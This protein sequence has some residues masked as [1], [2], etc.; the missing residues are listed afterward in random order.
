MSTGNMGNLPIIIIP[1]VCREKGSPFGDPDVCHVYG[2]AYASLSMA[3]YDFVSFVW[4]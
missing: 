2:M 1:A 3:V 4:Y